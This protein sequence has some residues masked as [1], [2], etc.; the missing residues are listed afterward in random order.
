MSI[1]SAMQAGVSGLVANSS[2]LAAIS[3]NIS[4]ANTVAYKRNETSFQSVVTG[5]AAK[6]AYNAGGVMSSTRQMV[7]QQGLLAQTNSAT[8][9]GIQ[10]QGFFVTTTK[11]SNLTATDARIFTRAGSFEVDANGYL[12]NSAGYYLQGWPV[13]SQ[14]AVHT[15]PSDLTRMSSINVGSI[16]GTADPT[17]TVSVNAN[18]EASQTPS[19]AVVANTYSAGGNSMA[20]YFD[21][22]APGVAGVKPDYSMQ[23]PVSDSQ[24]GQRTIEIDFLK[25]TTANEW[26][27]EVRAVPASD[28]TDPLGLLASGKVVFDSSGQLDMANSTLF[29]AAPG[30]VGGVLD[31]G[32]STGAA[33]ANGQWAAGLGIAS[34]QITI[35]FG[36]PGNVTQLASPSVTQSIAANGTAFGN[37]TDIQVDEQGNVSANFDNG[38]S[39][40]IA[41]VAIATFVNPNGLSPVSGNG[42]RT[43]LDSGPFNL[44]P[45][46]SGG[47]GTLSPSTLESSTVDLSSEFTGLITTQRAYSASSKIITTADQMLQELIS[48]IR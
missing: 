42:Y 27:A 35:N 31:I 8:D 23:I 44:K 48:I 5:A 15:D 26:Y 17:T 38:V 18:L 10:G 32:P 2:A 39:R 28:V 6:G 12:V 7:S 33:G 36:A 43:S 37:L 14:G 3:D 30:M 4:N 29:G 47:A 34:Q 16:G 46:G 21:P 24:G 19:A 9:L 40:R 20:K 45:P 13:D 25:N 1:S 22:A 11:A 41:Q